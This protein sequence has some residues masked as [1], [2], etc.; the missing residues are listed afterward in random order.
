MCAGGHLTRPKKHLAVDLP[1]ALWIEE[2]KGASQTVQI[3]G[4]FRFFVCALYV[5]DVG[6]STAVRMEQKENYSH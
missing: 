1:S 5:R 3:S 4:A 2:K 6:L